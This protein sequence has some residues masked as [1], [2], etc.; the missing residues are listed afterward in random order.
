MAE[1]PGDRTAQ[2]QGGQT[3]FRTQQSGFKS[4]APH[5]VLDTFMPSGNGLASGDAKR[6]LPQG[7]LLPAVNGRSSDTSQKRLYLDLNYGSQSGR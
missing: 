6:M 2:F 5:S 7:G 1:Y 3:S 4:F